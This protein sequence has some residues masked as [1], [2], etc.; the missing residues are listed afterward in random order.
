LI[1]RPLEKWQLSRRFFG[2][3]SLGHPFNKLYQ[4]VAFIPGYKRFTTIRRSD[5]HALLKSAQQE[6]NSNRPILGPG[7]I[8]VST[9]AIPG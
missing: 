3:L 1:L 9:Q 6:Q 7:N 2:H 8:T 5:E 4:L